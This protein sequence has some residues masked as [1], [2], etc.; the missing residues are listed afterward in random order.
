M[1]SPDP[2]WYH[3]GTNLRWWD[4]YRWGPHAPPR[5]PDEADKAAALIAHLGPFAGGFLPPLIVYLMHRK[6]RGSF[7][8]HHSAEAL[9]F[10]LTWLALAVVV[11]STI[12]WPSPFG[13]GDAAWF[14]VGWFVTMV[15]MAANFVLSIVAAVRVS[16]LERW[17]YPV[18]IRLIGS[19]SPSG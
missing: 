14:L 5:H 16:R 15:L 17:R 9:N 7:A 1:A 2:G 10:Q 6:R 19:R 13:L 4:G 12:W 8:R 11:T 3:D 18:S